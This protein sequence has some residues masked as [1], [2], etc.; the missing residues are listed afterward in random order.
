MKK[1]P[2]FSGLR[3]ELSRIGIRVDE[4]AGFAELCVTYRGDNVPPTVNATIPQ[5]YYGR[6]IIEVWSYCVKTT[7]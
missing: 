3:F 1:H 2:S 6:Y 5:T 4:N 7:F